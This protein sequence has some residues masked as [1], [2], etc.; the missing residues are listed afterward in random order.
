MD[1]TR[2]ELISVRFTAELSAKSADRLIS[3]IQSQND[4][5]PLIESFFPIEPPLPDEIVVC[6]RFRPSTGH[7]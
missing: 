1:L 6:N 3:G 2:P 7:Y 4:F 5:Y